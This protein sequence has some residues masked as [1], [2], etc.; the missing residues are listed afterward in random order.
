MDQK[1][2]PTNLAAYQPHHHHLE[3]TIIVIIIIIIIIIIN[4]C[5]SISG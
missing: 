5:S 1:E 4:L 3:K 2:T